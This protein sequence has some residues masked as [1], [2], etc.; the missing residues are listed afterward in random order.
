MSSPAQVQNVDRA[1]SHVVLLVLAV[2]SVPVAVVF[3]P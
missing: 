2:L 1:R 3:P